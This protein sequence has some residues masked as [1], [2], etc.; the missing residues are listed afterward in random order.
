MLPKILIVLVLVVIVASLGSALF[1]LVK[2]GDRRSPRTVR[3]LTL[4]IGLS[5]ALFLALL[6][7][8]ALGLLRPHG[9]RPDGPAASPR[10]TAPAQADPR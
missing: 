7:G 2:D 3:A 9:L 8:Y 1:Y 10:A 4:R 5:I 6:L